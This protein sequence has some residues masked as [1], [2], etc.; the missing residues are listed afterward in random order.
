MSMIEP[1]C[2]HN[3]LPKLLRD[4]CNRLCVFQTSGDVTFGK[5]NFA[6]AFMAGHEQ[7]RVLMLPVADAMLL[8]EVRH[9]VAKGWAKSYTLLVGKD[10][11]MSDEAI[12]VE[13]GDAVSKVSVIRDPMVRTGLFSL[14]GTDGTVVIV[15]DMLSHA[16]SGLKYYTGFYGSDEGFIQEL[17]GVVRSR[18]RIKGRK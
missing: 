11:G 5:F 9:D 3:Q 13:L 17:L 7:E 6:V 14:S 1:C 2:C 8:R 18:I 15:G 16:D 10:C 4:H 12:A